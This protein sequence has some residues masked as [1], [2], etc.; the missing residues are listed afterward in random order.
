MEAPS[1]L[2][3]D[4]TSDFCAYMSIVISMMSQ[5]RDRDKDIVREEIDTSVSLAW[6]NGSDAVAETIHKAAGIKHRISLE[7]IQAEVDFYFKMKINEA[8][9]ENGHAEVEDPTLALEALTRTLATE[10]MSRIDGAIPI[11]VGEAI[12]DFSR[13]ADQLADDLHE[14]LTSSVVP[15][16]E[17]LRAALLRAMPELEMNPTSSEE[18]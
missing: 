1:E 7:R 15:T 2:N 6:K 13:T 16:R 8:P 14:A 9:A 18:A 5:L 12:Q 11:A 17:E 3:S 4:K 10:C